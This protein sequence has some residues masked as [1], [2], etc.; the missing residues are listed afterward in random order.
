MVQAANVVVAQA[1][2]LLGAAGGGPSP[3]L[4]AFM[5]RGRSAPRPANQPGANPALARFMMGRA[6]AAGSEDSEGTPP[7]TADEAEQ[8]PRPPPPP[9]VAAGT[10]ACGLARLD[11]RQLSVARF[12]AEYQGRAPV[13]LTNVS[14]S[15]AATASWAR[16]EDV[17][18]RHGDLSL[19]LQEPELLG[20][21]GSFAPVTGSIS[22]RD[23]LTQPTRRQ[24]ARPS[25]HNRPHP[26]TDALLA[27]AEL[28]SLPTRTIRH[29]HI[30]SLG[31]T[32]H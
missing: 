24:G 26:L 11:A 21:R 25:F 12:R 29:H 9:R 18:R 22:L 3:E 27:G 32:R 2:L 1:L 16:V 31:K 6:T 13:L 14:G 30:C 10:G 5:G 23:Y 4:L 7:G 17:A 28:A 20:S 19:P 8:P 15:W